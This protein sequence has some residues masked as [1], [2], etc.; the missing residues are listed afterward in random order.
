MARLARLKND[1]MLGGVCGGLGEYFNVDSVVVR[2][3]FV[4]VTLLGGAGVLVYIILWIVVPE[5]GGAS[6]AEKIHQGVEEKEKSKKEKQLKKTGEDIAEEIKK[7]AKSL[8]NHRD[9]GKLIFATVLIFLGLI[10]LA[11]NFIP[12]WNFTKLWPLIL[13]IVGLAFLISSLDKE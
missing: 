9:E 8:K 13:V 12:F 4:A 7:S 6:Y 11:H 1:K 10:F 2:L 3:I 5:E